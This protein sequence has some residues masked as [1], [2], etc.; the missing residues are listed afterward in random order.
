MKLFFNLSLCSALLLLNANCSHAQNT[1]TKPPETVP[2]V[3][4]S[5][6]TGLW[7]E[8]AAFPQ[9]FQKGCYNT[10]AEYSLRDDGKITVV[11]TCNK[12]SFD[13]KL[14]VAK[15]KAKIEDKRSNAK[16]TVNFVW[17]LPWAKGDYWII[18]LGE[19][20]EY[21]VVGNPDRKYLWIL[22]RTSKMDEAL[23]DQI[24]ERL[25]TK[26]GYDVSKLRMTP[27]QER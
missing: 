20:Y 21:A 3:D 12:D 15:G 14:N 17:W 26:Q 9:S 13:G 6:Y 8:I 22:S 25:V 7:Y 4:L 18:D 19:N 2:F 27:Q 5:R 23:F 11:N 16:L 1:L 10:T 24:I